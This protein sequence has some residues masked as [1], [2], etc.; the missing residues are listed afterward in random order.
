MNNL[1]TCT[2]SDVTSLLQE[3]LLLLLE[4]LKFFQDVLE[5]LALRAE[6]G[7]LRP[8]FILF[9]FETLLVVLAAFA[10]LFALSQRRLCLSRRCVC[11]GLLALTLL[12]LCRCRCDIT[13]RLV[14]RG[15]EA[16]LFVLHRLLLL[17]QILQLRFDEL[18]APGF[19]WGSRACV[20]VATW[21]RRPRA[22]RAG[23]DAVDEVVD[24]QAHRLV[25]RLGEV[26]RVVLVLQ[27]LA[28]RAL[29]GSELE[30][31]T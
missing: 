3:R 16:P 10:F 29:A 22:S 27:R 7:P 30:L 14:N 13:L 25:P 26:Q 24:L 8:L 20:G 12:D 21:R 1:H 11:R 18:R 28:R 17:S 15:L 9:E 6:L 2:R 5:F 23:D 31:F 19:L 4:L